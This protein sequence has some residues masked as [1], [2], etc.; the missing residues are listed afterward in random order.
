MRR[1]LPLASYMTMVMVL[2]GTLFKI[3]HWPGANEMVIAGLGTVIFIIPFYFI[4][5]IKDTP[6]FFGKFAY[7]SLIFSTCVSILGVLFKIM[8]WPGASEMCIVGIASLIFPSLLFY[9]I[10]QAKK[11]N[12]NFKESYY[13]FF[14]ILLFCFLV[15]VMAYKP[16]SDVIGSFDYLNKILLTKNQKQDLSLYSH[17]IQDAY[18]YIENIKSEIIEK[19]GTRMS[20]DNQIDYR[21]DNMDAVTRLFMKDNTGQ[22]M[23]SL[24]QQVQRNHKASL[25]LL[26][27]SSNHYE[28]VRKNFYNMPSVGAVAKL[29]GIQYELLNIK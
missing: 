17:D 13:G 16:T 20:S 9:A 21:K 2:F 26:D 8:H 23:F 6:N 11:S 28:W 19:S 5:R 12:N 3:M 18:Q 14:G 27:K 29:T 1:F 10:Y 22:K 15:V 4:V 25:D 24:L 7:F